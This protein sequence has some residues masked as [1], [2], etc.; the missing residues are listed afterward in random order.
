MMLTFHSGS[1]KQ[2][3]VFIL[4]VSFHFL[5]DEVRFELARKSL[6]AASLLDRTEYESNFVI[7]RTLNGKIFERKK[8][9]KVV[10]STRKL[11]IIKFD[12][13]KTVWQFEIPTEA[14]IKL[15]LII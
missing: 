3:I 13:K 2:F 4:L 5:F 9:L 12:R 11:K 1:R 15:V 10:K 7:W 6:C 14:P 8:T